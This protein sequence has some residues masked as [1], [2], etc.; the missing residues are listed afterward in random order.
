MTRRTVVALIVFAAL[1]T[2]ASA[3][4]GG[5]QRFASVEEA[6]VSAGIL[7]GRPGPASVNWID[8]GERFSSPR[9]IDADAIGRFEELE[10]LAPLH[11]PPALRAIRAA[12]ELYPHLP[13]VAVFDTAFHSTLPPRAREYAL[14]ADIRARFGI[15]RYGFHGISHGDIAARNIRCWARSPGGE[16]PSYLVVINSHEVKQQKISGGCQ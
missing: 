13:H 2:P 3:Q 15:R 8:G 5:R 12:R 16:G 9:L 6:L 11:N 1:F 4:Q 10:R 14:P 7:T